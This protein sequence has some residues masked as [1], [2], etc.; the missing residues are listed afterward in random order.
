MA[1][2]STLWGTARLRKDTCSSGVSVIP[3]RPNGC[4]TT[5]FSTPV[6]FKKKLIS[7]VG[8]TVTGVSLNSP[9]QR[10]KGQHENPTVLP[11]SREPLPICNQTLLLPFSL[12]QMPD[13]FQIFLFVILSLSA[14]ASL[15]SRATPV[16]RKPRSPVFSS[17]PPDS[18]THL[19][20]CL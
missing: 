14:G 8:Q 9:N 5:H 19:L 2:G 16:F 11:S 4:V 13:D 17:L 1:F 12:A 7:T 10:Q 20:H 3:N 15:N 6:S 18:S